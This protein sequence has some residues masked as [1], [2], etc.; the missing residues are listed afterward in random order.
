MNVLN[1]LTIQFQVISCINS[2]ASV[3][4]DRKY[5]TQTTP[6]KLSPGLINYITYIEHTGVR[7]HFPY[8]VS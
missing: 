8:M 5:S 7:A 4:F 6:I 3:Y 1:Q 2:T